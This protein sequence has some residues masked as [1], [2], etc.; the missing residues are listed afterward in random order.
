VKAYSLDLR[1]RVA[2]AA[3]QGDLTQRAIADRFGVSERWVRK[4]LRQRRLTG[5][6]APK[7]HAGGHPR[8]LDDDADQRLRQAVAQAPDATLDELRQ[9]CGL[10]VTLT[11]VWRALRRLRLTRKK[12]SC[13]PRSS[14]TRRSRPSAPP[15][16]SGRPAPTRPASG[17]STRARPTPT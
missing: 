17:S 10:T 6:L 5:S 3:D 9:A 13:G 1:E 12:K 14:R 4:L 15:G 8:R 16:G 2:R 7:P 11:S